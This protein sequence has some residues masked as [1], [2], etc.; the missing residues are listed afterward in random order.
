MWK[1]ARV[2]TALGNQRAGEKVRVMGTCLTP[3][4]QGEAAE[5]GYTALGAAAAA[6]RERAL[7]H[8][9][10]AR[11][12]EVE[13]ASCRRRS[14]RAAA[15]L[16]A[17]SLVDHYSPPGAG[18]PEAAYARGARRQGRGQ[19]CCTRGK[20]ARPPEQLPGWPRR[21]VAW[22]VLRL[23]HSVATVAAGAA[24]TG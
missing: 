2:D 21:A 12:R 16:S 6:V 8:H 9:S 18:C 13:D 7:P 22:G 10:S 11:R 23:V 15:A 5:R 24:V 17:S 3:L 20:A 1:V 19:K 14:S 4:Q